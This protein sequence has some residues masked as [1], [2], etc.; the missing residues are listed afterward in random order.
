VFGRYLIVRLLGRGGMG[1]VYE[2]T[3]LD[4]GRRVALKTL[5]RRH[6]ESAQARSR[7]MRE[8]Q[9]ASRIQHPNVADV[10]DV[11][12]DESHPFLVMEFLEGEDLS[13]L[14]AR[15]AP[16]SVE[17]TANLLV[18]VIAG[19]AAAHAQGVL[20]RDLKPENIFL[21]AEHNGIRPKVLDFGISKVMNEGVSNLTDT[22][23][24]MGTP[25][26]VSPE[27]AQGAK[28]IG[29]A[30]DQ[31]S[32]GV[33]LY[34]CTTGLRPI[35]ETTLYAM[36]RRIVS[37]DFAPPRQVRPAMPSAFEA[38]ILRAMALD[39]VKRFPTT[40]A[41]GEALLEFAGPTIRAFYADELSSRGKVVP[42]VG[43]EPDRSVP[44]LLGTTLEDSVVQRDAPRASSSTWPWLAG[45]A[46]AGALGL[47]LLRATTP[48]SVVDPEAK[49]AGASP[50]DVRSPPASPPVAPPTSETT[51]FL[52]AASAATRT[53]SPDKA[54][55]QRAT[56][57]STK[58]FEPARAANLPATPAPVST[59]APPFGSTVPAPSARPHRKRDYGF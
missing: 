47:A 26:Y 43:E 27:Q 50:S 6:L 52:S 33:I 35:E 22:G 18:P 57:P 36:I 24:F 8:G 11:S 20:H 55:K 54:E 13:Q 15:D 17:R 58:S 1:A 9:A 42:E 37:G 4:L 28:D 23:A 10:F 7:F 39:P 51:S 59:V 49:M 2:A 40:R 48:T 29:V 21:S 12:T 16:L 45:G 3:H 46:L 32:L 14:I 30:A 25:Y 19:V 56:V 41:L 53:S 38:V 5:H 31:Y 44:P 34:E